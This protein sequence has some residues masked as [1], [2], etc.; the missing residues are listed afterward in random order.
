MTLRDVQAA[1]AA[2]IR[3]DAEAAAT[4]AGIV[5]GGLA[6]AARLGVYRRNSLAIFETALGRTYAVVLRRAGEGAFRQYAREYRAAHPS[7]SGDLYWVGE[8]FPRWLQQRLAGSD[9]AWLAELARLEWLC[10]EILC[11]GES[12]PAALGELGHVPPERLADVRFEFQPWL[13][14]LTSPYPVWQVWR[15]NQ[16]GEDGAPVDLATGPEH[17]VLGRAGSD[18]VLR[19]VPM[20]EYEFVRQ[21]HAGATLGEALESAGLAV[22]ALGPTLDWLFREKFIA[23]IRPLPEATT[24]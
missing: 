20:A 3:G 13:R 14:L 2:G 16:P 9:Y 5:A 23:A 8:A 19:S 17:V 15:A 11:A 21:L 18:L 6:P 10:E 12:A 4:A 24:T 7:P 1:F 22:E